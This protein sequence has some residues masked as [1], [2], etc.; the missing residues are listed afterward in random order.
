MKTMNHYVHRTFRRILMTVMCLMVF[1]GLSCAMVFAANGTVEFDQDSYSASYQAV[2][3]TAQTNNTNAGNADSNAFSLQVNMECEVQPQTYHVELVYDTA[4]LRY[5]SGADS[6]ENGVIVLEG[7]AVSQSIKYDIHFET[8]SGG[9]AG[10]YVQN[11]VL[12]EAD[13]TPVHIL[14]LA[15]AEISIDG[16]DSSGANAFSLNVPDVNLNVPLAG[17]ALLNGTDTYYIIDMERY[18]PEGQAWQYQ[19]VADTYQDRQIMFMT[20]GVQKMR[21]CYLIDTSGSVYMYAYGQNGQFYPCVDAGE[22]YYMSALACPELPEGMNADDV[23]N[24]NILY[25]QH[26][27]GTGEFV[28][29]DAVG[30]YSAWKSPEELEAEQKAQQASVTQAPEKQDK[31]KNEQKKGNGILSRL[32][33]LPARAYGLFAAVLVLV[34]FVIMIIRGRSKENHEGQNNSFYNNDMIQQT[35]EGI[36]KEVTEHVSEKV[37]E[38]DDR[39]AAENMSP[40]E[41]DAGNEESGVDFSTGTLRASFTDEDE[42]AE[43]IS[44]EEDRIEEELKRAADASADVP[45]QTNELSFTGKLDFADGNG[46]GE[47]SGGPDPEKKDEAS[48]EMDDVD[49]FLNELFDDED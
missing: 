24:D 26:K 36:G 11:A 1:M 23:R 9:T 31:E 46:T 38:F 7:T 27:D 14:A 34:I 18:Q 32:A 10:I 15:Q 8:I 33:K 6:E 40:E 12:T 13:G 39:E 41:N 37:D 17:T 28:Q 43:S 47:Q 4:R 48:R 22:Y 45:D 5:V 35:L 20:D 3:E 19:L 29:E 30:N 44:D 21:Y 25:L 16:E 49:A 2:T 42:H